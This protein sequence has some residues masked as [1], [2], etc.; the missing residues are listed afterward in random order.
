MINA[1]IDWKESEMI[2]MVLE[3]L[4]MTERRQAIGGQV[5]ALGVTLPSLQTWRLKRLKT[6]KELADAAEVSRAT[7]ANA[8]R[9]SRIAYTTAEK[10]AT[11]LET[12]VE[13]LQATPKGS[14]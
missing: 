10:L 13:A 14:R 1:V 5:R 8:E 2:D 7:V 6:Q 3:V 4:D 11:A 9:G 12:T